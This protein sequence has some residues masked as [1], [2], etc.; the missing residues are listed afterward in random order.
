MRPRLIGLRLQ[1]PLGMRHRLLVSFCEEMCGGDVEKKLVHP[2]IVGREADRLLDQGNG[3]V[4]TAE[5]RQR[6]AQSPVGERGAW[7]ETDRPFEPRDGRC[8]RI[9]PGAPPR[10]LRDALAL[11]RHAMDR[12]SSAL[13]KNRLPDSGSC[14]QREAGEVAKSGSRSPAVVMA[15]TTCLSRR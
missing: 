4:G 3:A 12:K 6:R 11:L 7:V 8:L 2:G 5:G 15:G 9:P 14:S 10:A 13:L 1:A